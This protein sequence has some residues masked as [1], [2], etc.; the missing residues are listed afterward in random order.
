MEKCIDFLLQ[1]S[2][3]VMNQKVV[4]K[5]NILYFKI[6]IQII[7]HPNIDNYSHDLIAKRILINI[8]YFYI[9]FLEP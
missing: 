3:Y 1:I 8:N 7:H 4:F 2:F 5:P 6:F 9:H